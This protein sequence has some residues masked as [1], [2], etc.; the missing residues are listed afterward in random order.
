[1]VKGKYELTVVS[2][3]K[4]RK[5]AFLHIIYNLKNM[6]SSVYNAKPVYFKLI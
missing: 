3:L 4:V 2:E 5:G 1:M 6:A